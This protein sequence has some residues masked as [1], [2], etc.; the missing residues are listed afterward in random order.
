MLELGKK[1][2]NTSFLG[3]TL[4]TTKK[5]Y[6]VVTNEEKKI[7]SLKGICLAIE[8]FASTANAIA[9]AIA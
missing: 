6:E 2:L 4:I 5:Y 7:S 3:T 1:D 8:T 9:I